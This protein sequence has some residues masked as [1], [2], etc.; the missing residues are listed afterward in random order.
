MY[1]VNVYQAVIIQDHSKEVFSFASDIKNM[2]G[3]E[4][5][6]GLQ[7]VNDN[8]VLKINKEENG[9]YTILPYKKVLQ[10]KYSSMKDIRKDYQIFGKGVGL[11]ETGQFSV[12]I[13]IVKA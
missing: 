10:S 12:I 5:V 3:L 13:E 2:F 7:K 11:H 6:N 1:K 8:I 9:D 4:D